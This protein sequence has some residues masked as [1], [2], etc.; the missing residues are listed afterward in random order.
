MATL[1]RPR[2]A[3]AASEVV[4][5]VPAPFPTELLER[6]SKENPFI[7][8]EERVEEVEPQEQEH[9]AEEGTMADIMPSISTL[10]KSCILT[11]NTLL[12]GSDE[13]KL[14]VPERRHSMP[15]SP[16][17]SSV[18][19]LETESS[20][21]ALGTLVANLRMKQATDQMLQFQPPTSESD[22]AFELR[23][24]VHKA[25]PLLSPNDAAL[26]N[27]LATILTYF[28]RLLSLHSLHPTISTSTNTP[29][30]T[31]LP[32]PADMYEALS[33]QLN[34]LQFERLTSQPSSSTSSNQTEMAILWNQIDRELESIVSMCKERT[35]RLPMFYQENQPPQYDYEDELYDF[36]S[37]PEYDGAGRPSLD[38][39]R[40]R[41]LEREIASPSTSSRLSDEKMRLDLEGVAM[42][43]DRLYLVAPQLHNQR[44]ELKS[45]KLAQLE[46]ARKE[47]S[48]SSGRKGKEREKQEL[49]N[50]IEML[51]KAS[52]RTLKDQ[53]VVLEHGMQSRLEKAKIKDLAKREAFVEGLIQHSAAGRLH[54][55]D[56]ILT[57]RTKDPQAK[58][59][60][61]E[62]IRES[63]PP[64]SDLLKDPSIMLTLPEFVAQHQPPEDVG[65][66][67]DE[68]DYSG[69]SKKKSSSRHR[70]LSAPP[71]AWLRSISSSS[72]GSGTSSPKHK[73]H[74]HAFD[75]V[76]VA[77]NHENL[78]HVLV[79]FTA[80]GQVPNNNLTAEILPPFP[81]HI[82]TGGDNLV[83]KSGSSASLPLI[84]PAR[85]TPG[86]KE[87]HAQPGHFEI[88]LS[89]VATPGALIDDG[90]DI[91]S[92]LLDATKLTAVNPSSFICASCSLPLIQVQG[93][94]SAPSSPSPPPPLSRST[95]SLSSSSASVHPKMTYRDLP[96]EHWEELVEAWMCHSDQKL[97]DQ[98]MKHGK[99]GFWP[100][101]GQAFVGGSY[102]LFEESAVAKQNLLAAVD[103]KTD[104]QED[105]RW[106]STDGRCPSQ[107]HMGVWSTGSGPPGLFLNVWEALAG[108]LCVSAAG[109]LN[110]VGATPHDDNWQTR[111]CLCGAIIGRSTTKTDNATTTTCFRVL[112][113]AIRPVTPN[114]SDSL[115]IPLSAF[116]VEDMM[117]YVHAH[118]SYRFVIQDEEDEKA[119]ILIWLFKPKIRLSYT[120]PRSRAIPKSG[121]ITAA[122]VLYKLL[123]PNEAKVD[124]KTL[125]NK[126]PGFPQAEYL[127]YPMSICRRVASLL[128][129]SNSAYPEGL[130]MMT[131]LEVGWLHRR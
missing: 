72:Q 114:P 98:V 100:Q 19:Q 97:H 66:V 94:P 117:E 78:H 51:G 49:E 73:N 80:T 68:V 118:A 17:T 79:F 5:G 65:R 25:S 115:K 102:I 21:S 70:S 55:Q 28:G 15:S 99:A 57:P 18:H 129:E 38:K 67:R 101:P 109:W 126:Y 81:E 122:K 53:S 93:S 27:S 84:L 69:K 1:T 10:E 87:I 31:D 83:I 48:V 3:P 56:A 107:C 22:L 2:T 11:L 29:R 33:R 8:R 119:R 58:L 82:S 124:L 75:I 96:S 105:R 106:G 46:K 50:I 103:D 63:I 113:Y 14:I 111:R 95:S 104:V 62:F 130:R 41:K 23:E 44:V 110:D 127:S 92:P 47:G 116:I 52:E 4:S 45:S 9:V 76:Y 39:Y 24:R 13:W 43:I 61:P 59:T 20:T 37:L 123:G 88:K 16:G 86:R 26:A 7:A 108:F 12:S 34:D 89:T 125:L 36:E 40:D 64:D 42:A 74:E 91:N 30:T 112:K 6:R 128:K 77:E 120:T 60:F 32:P 90:A 35:E 121:S 71:L 85:T 54:G 131:G